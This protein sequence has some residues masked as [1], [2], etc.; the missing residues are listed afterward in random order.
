MKIKNI[1]DICIKNIKRGKINKILNYPIIDKQ[2]NI[3]DN[4]LRFNDNFEKLLK[5]LKLRKML[6]SLCQP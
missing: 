4:L 1:K 2:V 6:K 3:N 5:R